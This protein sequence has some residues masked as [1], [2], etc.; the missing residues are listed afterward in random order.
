M[1]SSEMTEFGMLWEKRERAR[2][3]LH[4]EPDPVE[5]DRIRERMAPIQERMAELYPPVAGLLYC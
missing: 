2:A 3:A 4:I 5:R 1:G